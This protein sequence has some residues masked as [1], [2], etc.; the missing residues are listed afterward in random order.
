VNDPKTIAEQLDAAKTG[1]EFARVINGLFGLLE[2][3]IDAD[4]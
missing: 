4:E 3:A 2:R 1:E